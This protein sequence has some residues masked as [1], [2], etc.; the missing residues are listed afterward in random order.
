MSTVLVYVP[1]MGHTREGHP[2][3]NAR[4]KGLL[5]VLDQLGVLSKA[6][7]IDAAPATAEQLRR[8]HTPGLIEYA[9]QV[10][11]QGGGLLD[12]GD[13]YATAESYDL[14]LQA[15]GGCCAA[16]DA[17]MSGQARNGFALVRPPGHHAERDR[18]GGFCLFNNVAVAARQAQVIHGA[19]RVLVLDFDVHHGNGTQ[20]VFY[21]DDSVLFVS[22]HL[23]APYFYP[24]IGSLGETGTGEGQ[25]FTINVPL[26]PRVGDEGYGRVLNE[27][28]RPK[29]V[30]F[31]PEVILVSIGFDAH[32]QDPLAMA[33]LTLTGYARLAQALVGLA[34]EVCHG[35]ILFVLEGGYRL[36]ALRYGIL[37]VINALIGRDEARDPLGPMPY[38]EQDITPLLRQLRQRHL[39]S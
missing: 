29:A 37:N 15:V 33:G 20:D 39:L 2:E 3:S 34:G 13:T 1:A 9:R 19:K 4:L 5:P 24:G 7:L 23:F 22:V 17:I 25:G 6:R 14:A 21:Q 12:Y 26:P 30:A 8:V 38:P 27:L 18:A 28:V 11:R 32:W 36:E 10:S 35:R 31:N 16:I